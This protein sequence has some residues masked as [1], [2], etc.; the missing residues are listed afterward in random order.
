MNIPSDLQRILDR[1]KASETHRDESNLIVACP[2][3]DDVMN[4]CGAIPSRYMK[5]PCWVNGRP[6]VLVFDVVG[7]SVPVPLLADSDLPSF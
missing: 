4:L 2:T 5:T 3:E 6:S 1:F 7:E